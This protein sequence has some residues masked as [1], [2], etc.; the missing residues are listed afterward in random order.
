VEDQAVVFRV[1][2]RQ[3]AAAVFEFLDMS[4]QA[5]LLK[6][7]GQE[8]VASILND[9]AADDRTALLEELPAVATKQL[10]TLLTPEERA[11]ALSL[12]GYPAGSIGRLMT[13]HYIAVAQDWTIQQ[14]LDYVRAHGQDSETLEMLYVLDDKGVLID[15]IRLREFLLTSTANRVADLMDFPS[16]ENFC[17][18]SSRAARLYGLVETSS[19]PM[20][21]KP[22]TSSRSSDTRLA[23]SSGEAME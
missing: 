2:P 12:L 9:M 23:L 13:P 21:C 7:L 14:V 1:L 11:I 3:C 22:G 19:M 8:Q 6:A 17:S 15:D 4:A 16:D 18:S 10:L 20:R 5:A